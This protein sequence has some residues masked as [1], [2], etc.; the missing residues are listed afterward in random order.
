MSLLYGALL[1]Q[2]LLFHTGNMKEVS[3]SRFSCLPCSLH[4]KLSDP[5]DGTDMISKW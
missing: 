3:T 5:N 4:S 2:A 1:H